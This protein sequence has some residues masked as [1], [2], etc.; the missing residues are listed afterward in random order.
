MFYQCNRPNDMH[1]NPNSIKTPSTR[2][3]LQPHH[4]GDEGVA[5][6]IKV[7]VTIDPATDNMQ[8]RR[9]LSPHGVAAEEVGHPRRRPRLLQQLPPEHC[10]LNRTELF[11]IEIWLTSS[12]WKTVA[13]CCECSAYSAVSISNFN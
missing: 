8:K 10:Q 13:C 9:L 4:H 3:N 11:L 1:P 5:L 2:L 6:T 7:L 12:T